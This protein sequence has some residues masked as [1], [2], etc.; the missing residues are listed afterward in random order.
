MRRLLSGWTAGAVVLALA[1]GLLYATLQARPGRAA[2]P[3]WTW[4][5]PLIVLATAALLCAALVDSMHTRRVWSWRHAG[6]LALLCAMMATFG[7]YRAFPSSHDHAPSEVDFRLP[8]DGPVT[9]A[10]G[11]P[12]AA[13]NYHVGT[14]SERWAYDLL[15]T[16]D[17]ITHRGD[18]RRLTDYHAFDQPVRSPA[19]GRVVAVRDGD[20]DAS[21]GQP[22]A[23]RR[24]GNHIV[25]EVTPSEYLVIAHLKAGTIGVSVGQQVGRGDIVGRVGNSGNSTEPHVHLHLQDHPEPGAGEGIPL[26]F[27]DYV[28]ADGTVVRRG[29]PDGGRRGGRYTGS[30]VRNATPRL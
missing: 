4:G 14:P 25:V 13:V 11:G 1:H 16:R 10:W 5:P 29:T 23:S 12:T 3:L 8:V 21:P 6:G 2:I 28:L 20:P 27:S 19:A 22:D 9:V 18:G 26:L 7:V 24:A 17:G 30:V 15:V